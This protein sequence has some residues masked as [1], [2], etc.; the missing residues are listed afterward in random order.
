MIAPSGALSTA[1]CTADINA[2]TSPSVAFFN[3]ANVILLW[4]PM[5]LCLPGVSADEGQSNNVSQKRQKNQSHPA[6]DRLSPPK[7]DARL[8]RDPGRRYL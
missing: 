3:S 5:A 7:G 6:T 2:A 8:D 1:A 4:T